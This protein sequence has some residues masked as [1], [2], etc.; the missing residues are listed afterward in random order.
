MVDR[1]RERGGDKKE[2]GREPDTSLT[3]GGVVSGTVPA[4]IQQGGGRDRL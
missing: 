2:R 4:L 3:A 1:E